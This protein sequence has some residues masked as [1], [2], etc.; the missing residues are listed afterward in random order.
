MRRK[1]GEEF[2]AHVSLSL[3]YNNLGVPK[4]MISYS[5]DITARKIAEDAIIKHARQLEDAN[6]ELEA[7]S[8]SVSHDLRS[9]LRAIHGFGSMLIDDYSESLEPEAREYL[10]RIMKNAIHMG[11]LIDDLLKLSRVNRHKINRNTIN[12]TELAHKIIST[13][14]ESDPD[15]EVN[16]TIQPNMQIVADV[17]LMEIALYNLLQNAWKYTRSVSNAEITFAKMDDDDRNIFYVK[18]NGIGFDMQYAD[19]LFSAFQRLHGKEVEGTG[20]GLATVARI[21]HRHGGSIWAVG[22]VNKGAKFYFEI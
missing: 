10:Q 2:Y 18:D 5:V 3:L 15:R 16:V 21:I 14:R 19:K 6:H 11:R 22:E 12:L 1:D 8:Y 13:L 20:I 9:P 17:S 7:F 4:G